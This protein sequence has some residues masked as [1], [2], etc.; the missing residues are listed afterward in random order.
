MAHPLH[1]HLGDNPAARPFRNVT[2]VSSPAG[3]KIVRILTFPLPPRPPDPYI[4]KA[5]LRGALGVHIPRGL[6]DPEGSCPCPVRGPEHTAPTYFVGSR[7]RFSD[8]FSWLRT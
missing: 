6:I 5:G 2:E 4:G 3:R 1:A 8:G 7:D